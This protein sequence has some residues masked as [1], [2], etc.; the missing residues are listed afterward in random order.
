MVII[1]LVIGFFVL[2][3]DRLLPIVLPTLFAAYLIYGFVR[4]YISRRM[5]HE[6]EDEGEDDEEIES[7]D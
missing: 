3:W 4:P 2:L 7:T 1:V 5:R 6:I